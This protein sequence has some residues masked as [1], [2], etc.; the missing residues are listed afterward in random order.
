[1]KTDFF[2]VIGHPVS[3]S[4]SPELFRA[5]ADETGITGGSYIRA[6]GYQLSGLL[7]MLKELNV[8]G[9]NVTKPYKE[10]IIPQLSSLTPDARGIGAVNTVTLNGAGKILTG[11]NTDCSG[12]LQPLISGRTMTLMGKTV[13][14]AGAGGSARAA[15]FSLKKAGASVHIT[16]RNPGRGHTVSR[17]FSVP[18]HP[19]KEIS[20]ALSGFD[21]LIWTI[22]AYPPGLKL[23]LHSHQLVLDANYRISP[24]SSYFGQAKRLDGLHWL[25]HQGWKS[26]C[27]FTGNEPS[28]LF[29][30]FAVIRNRLNTVMRPAPGIIALTG[31]MGAGK[32]TIGR[33]LAAGLGWDFFDTDKM[34]ENKA[35]K[36]IEKMFIEN[37]ERE[38]RK[39]ETEQTL[40]ALSGRK[41][42]IALGGGA[43]CTPEITRELQKSAF[44]VWLYQPPEVIEKRCSTHRGRPLFSTES[45]RK[46][47]RTRT[48]A[49]IS[50]S[51]LIMDSTGASIGEFTSHLL[52]EFSFFVLK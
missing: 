31:F 14:V 51:N 46:M 3:H 25:V 35:G 52:S 12:V 44:T 10:S 36:S 30:D 39:L 38:F 15:V 18:F 13:L 11:S 34:C 6:G 2:A 1:M 47:L 17:L 19:L 22:P 9:F 45:F 26:F 8:C 23:E 41:R 24:D 32:S 29:P 40:K 5:F 16:N 42:V 20:S 37:G 21:I 50:A 7:A 28:K 4:L 27:A 48:P 33:A 43:V 49:Y